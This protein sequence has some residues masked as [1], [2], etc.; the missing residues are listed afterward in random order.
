[1]SFSNV[2]VGVNA[3]DG[4]GDPIRTAFQK[5][6]DNFAFILSS[7]IGGGGSGN[8]GPAAYATLAGSA[9]SVDLTFLNSTLANLSVVNLSRLY[10]E[11]A[12]VNSVSLTNLNN[13]LTTVGYVNLTR[14]YSELANVSSVSLTNLN[15]ALS[16]VGYVN[17]TSLGNALANLSSVNLDRLNNALATVGSVNLD[18]LNSALANINYSALANVTNLITSISSNATPPVSIVNNLSTPGYSNGHVVFNATDGGLYVWN[19]TAWINPRELSRN[20]NSLSSVQVVDELPVTGNFEGRQVLYNSALYI[21]NNGDFRSATEVLTPSANALTGIEVYYGASLPNPATSLAGRT[22]FWNADSN[23]YINVG[24]AWNNYNSYIIG[25]GSASLGA[26]SVNSAALQDNVITAQKIVSGAIIAGKIA[27]G[28]IGASEIAANAITA[29]KIA[30]NAV[31]AGTIAAGVISSDQIAAESLVAA[32]IAANAIVA[33]KIAAAAVSTTELAA[34][35]I[36]ADKI[37]TLAVYTEALQANVVTAAKIATGAV[38]AEAIQANAVTAAKIAANS[39]TAVQL[40]ANAVYANAIQSNAITTDKI[41]ANAITAVQIAANSIY[42]NALQANSIT[43]SSIAANAIT[44]VQIAANAVYAN[45]IESNAITSDKIAANAITSVK[46]AAN[47]IYAGALQ[48]NAVT[49]NTIAANS[50]TAVQLAA[51]AVYANAI[52]TNAITADKVAAN[53]ITSVKIAANSIYAGALQANAVTANTIAANSITAIQLAANAVYANAIQT[54]AITTDKIAANAVTA[55]K[56][57]TRGLIVRDAA[58]DILLG[59]GFISNTLVLALSNGTTTTLAGLGSSAANVITYIGAYANDAAAT[60]ATGGTNINSVYRNTTDGNNYIR[61][62][63]GWTLFLEKGSTGTPGSGAF[64]GTVYRQ[65]ATTPIAPTGGSYNFTTN[66]LL[67]PSLWSNTAPVTNTTPTWGVHYTFAGTGTVTGGTWSDPYIFARLQSDGSTFFAGIIY[68]QSASQPATPTGGTFN[69]ATSQLIAPS[70]WSNTAPSG[71]TTPTW[72]ASFLFSTST[73]NATVT[74]TTWNTPRIAYQNG[75]NGTSGTNGQNGTSGTNGTN[76]TNGSAGRRGYLRVAKSGYNAWDDN[77]AT[78]AITELGLGGPFTRD[79]V[80]LYNTTGTFS[81]T[82]FWDGTAWAVISAYIDGGLVV[83]GS[84]SAAKIATSAITADKIN[85]GAI[86]TA[87]LA[88]EGISG[89]CICAGTLSADRIASGTVSL[90]DGSFALGAGASITV[91]GKTYPAQGVFSNSDCG[92]FTGI[93]DHA[94]CGYGLVAGNRAGGTTQGAAGIFGKTLTTAYGGTWKSLNVFAECNGAIFSTQYTNTGGILN[95]F[96]GAAGTNCGLGSCAGHFAT[97][98]GFASPRVF[99]TLA[100]SSGGATATY[101]SF[102]SVTY[103]ASLNPKQETIIGFRC[104]AA[105]RMF[106]LQ[107]TTL[108]AGSAVT[109][110]QAILANDQGSAT[111]EKYGMVGS[112]FN[113]SG[114]VCAQ[115]WVATGGGHSFYTAAG[116]VAPFTGSHD[117]YLDVEVTPEPGDIM[118]DVQVISKKTISDAITKVALSSAPNQKAVVGIYTHTVSVADAN[119]TPTSVSVFQTISTENN[120]KTSVFNNETGEFDETPLNTNSTTTKLVIAEQFLDIH[121]SHKYINI[122]SLGEGLVNVCGE[123]GDIEIGDLITTSSMPGKGMKQ[124]DDI[125][126]NY[127]VGKAR[128]AVTFSSSS[129]V[130]QIAVIYYCG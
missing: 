26:G 66:Q 82:R 105:C 120:N 61:T 75:T 89:S 35:A 29:G 4:S 108:F 94:T 38:Y 32:V 85:A 47:S 107:S 16:T 46:I 20:A 56:I 86:T 41:A 124:A 67:A 5:I 11:L 129:E 57:D 44:A 15:N 118:I 103:D 48:A 87:K 49:A 126:R 113:S 112:A 96:Y 98:D 70:G 59:S 2:N 27:A 92:K 62:A 91:G 79:E 43:T 110:V 100:G 8:G 65:S 7:N 116:T 69:F 64:T 40:A 77:A 58:G 53:A 88:S 36:T 19:G 84:I 104:G 106:G 23:L 30:A 121:M 81:Q 6:N 12:N 63:S 109:S 31:V 72:F 22:L 119:T 102:S 111:F 17:L 52:Q 101:S 37:A 60:A 39:I 123:G 42:A 34:G 74:A 83:T 122:N 55:A 117:A 51:N 130:K 14:L 76:G 50:I 1:M 125:I 95:L 90:T 93:F 99:S 10:S 71:S 68:Q 24:G 115:G 18:N 73:I 80:V 3:N 45:A 54:N 28:A 9:Q 114:S 127:T 33:G 97:H 21:Y 128:E 25:S 13:A 78:T